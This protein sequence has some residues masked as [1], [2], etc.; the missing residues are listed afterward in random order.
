MMTY[1]TIF[2]FAFL[3]ALVGSQVW[4]MNQEDDWFDVFSDDDDDDDENDDDGGM[5]VRL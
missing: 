4:L 1:V 3:G 2:F 5:S